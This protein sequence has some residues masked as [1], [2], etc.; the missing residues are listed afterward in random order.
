MNIL[1]VYSRQD[2]Q[3]AD[4]PLQNL[5]QI[6]FGISYISALLRKHGHHTRLIVLSRELR[7]KKIAR[8]ISDFSPGLICFS[9]VYSEYEF[10]AYVARY[11]KER[12]PKIFLLA[13]GPHVSLNHEVCFFGWYRQSLD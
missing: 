12:Y 7:P 8:Y 5:Q 2:S 3:S 4:K 1:F 6:Q 11:I 9:A 13:G 10:I